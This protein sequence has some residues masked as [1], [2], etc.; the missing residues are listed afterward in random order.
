MKYSLLV[1]FACFGLAVM[2]SQ[3]TVNCSIS[4]P[5]G[6]WAPVSCAIIAGPGNTVNCWINA[7]NTGVTCC[8]FNAAGQPIRD[9]HRNCP[10][11][12]GGGGGDLGGPDI[13]V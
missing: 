12:G 5:C 9:I 3:A 1:I 11:G 2:P 13:P 6:P 4:L 8:E 7:G 10:T